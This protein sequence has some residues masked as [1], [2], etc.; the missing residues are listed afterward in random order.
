MNFASQAR[1]ILEYMETFPHHKP[2]HNFVY[3]SGEFSRLY[4][5]GVTFWI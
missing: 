1:L 3:S 5:I 2:R 4:R